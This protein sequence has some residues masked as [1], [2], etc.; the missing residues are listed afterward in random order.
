MANKPEDFPIFTPLDKETIQK[1][2]LKISNYLYN[3][4]DIIKVD[5]RKIDTAMD[6]M[7]E[8]IERIEKRRIYFHIFY[9]GCKMGEL[10]EGSLMCFW[11]LK[12]TPFH[13]NG[14]SNNI[15]N[16]KIALCLFMNMLHYHTQKE[17]MKL[18][19]TETIVNDIYYGFRFRDLSKEA[20]MILAES[21]IN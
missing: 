2:L 3:V 1:M 17:K 20:I 21:L 4:S 5:H 16:A 9:D 13:Y 12:L 11:I 18:N 19:I 15:L 6:I 14:I 7:Y 8:I 10:N